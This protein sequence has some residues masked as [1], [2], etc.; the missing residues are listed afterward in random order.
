MTP[1]SDLLR[2]IQK[3]VDPKEKEQLIDRVRE[4]IKKEEEYF[5]KHVEM[6]NIIAERISTQRILRPNAYSKPINF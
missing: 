5:K 4:L 3:C 2:Q 1:I 6:M